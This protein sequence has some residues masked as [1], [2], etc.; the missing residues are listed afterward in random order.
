MRA[1][2]DP[3]WGWS[4]SPIYRSRTPA[5]PGRGSLARPRARRIRGD[6]QGEPHALNR[7]LAL[8]DRRWLETLVIDRERGW[9]GLFPSPERTRLKVKTAYAFVSGSLDFSVYGEIR[10]IGRIGCSQAARRAAGRR[11]C[12]S[13]WCQVVSDMGTT[14]SPTC[15]TCW[16]WS[17]PTRPAGWRSCCPT[18][19]EPPD[20]PRVDG[21][22]RSLGSGALR[23]GSGAGRLLR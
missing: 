13:A 14:R 6:V 16:A 11:R 21:I 23:P 3:A 8:P 22:L 17:A 10:I 12:C 9:V 4:S 19:G 7:R 20:L 1:V 2:G 15:A 18:G 5:T